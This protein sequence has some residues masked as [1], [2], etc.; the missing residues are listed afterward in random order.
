MS[1]LA[2]FEFHPRAWSDRASSA[3]IMPVQRQLDVALRHNEM[4]KALYHRLVLQYGGNVTFENPSGVGT[5]VDLV[6][7]RENGYW[8]YEI[9]TAQ[10]PRAC[11]REAIG[12]LLE[13]AF[14]PGA[15]TVTRLIVVGETPIEE[16]GRE[17]LRR[18]KER[19]SL[20]LEY[21]NISLNDVEA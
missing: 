4:Q 2:P 10:S 12:Q 8:F 13:Y 9:K 6:V 20:P 1:S 11:L 5:R 16:N 19:F 21:E 7:Q 17:Y 3:V 15:P 14:W 18:L